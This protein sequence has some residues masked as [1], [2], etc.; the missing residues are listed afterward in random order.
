MDTQAKI[1]KMNAV[2]NKMEDIK[3]S[4]QS[5]INKIGQ[6]EVD[7]FEIKSDDLDKELDKVMKK[8]TRSFEIINEA[9]E[10]FEIKRNRL[11][12]EA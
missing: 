12:N 3:N 2:L 4:Q 5:L 1:E 10:E 6:V 7:L 9:I 11:E 8:A